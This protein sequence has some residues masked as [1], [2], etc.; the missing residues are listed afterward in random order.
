MSLWNDLLR[1]EDGVA[2]PGEKREWIT[3]W[4]LQ[5]LKDNLP[6]NRMVQALLNP[7]G[8]DAPKAFLA[9]V[10]WGGDVSAS[11]S[12]AMQAAQNSA[13]VFLGANLKCASCHDSFVN[14][15]KVAQTFGLAAFFSAE[16]LEIARC[17]MK[18]GVRAVP[19]SSSRRWRKVNRRRNYPNAVFRW[20]ECLPRPPTVASRERWSI[21]TGN[22]FSA[23]EL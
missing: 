1:N 8:P 14:R 2:Y 13:Q 11:Q 7:E 10:N 3:R 21:A 23:V 16:P 19:H 4:L 20:P 15:W 5:A 18:T 12:A 6:Y 17:E 9:G 22:F